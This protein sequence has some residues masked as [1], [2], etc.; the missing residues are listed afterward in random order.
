MLLV[1]NGC[2][3][4]PAGDG[5]LSF[6]ISASGNVAPNRTLLSNALNQTYS[7][8]VDG[9]RLWATDYGTGA[10]VAF[11]VNANG[12]VTPSRK[13]EGSN[14]RVVGAVRSRGRS[15]DRRYLR[16]GSDQ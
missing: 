2:G 3:A 7:I 9:S 6:P 14:A 12:T 1:S 11:D 16:D 10:L 5:V 13:I 8:A 4:G 15:G